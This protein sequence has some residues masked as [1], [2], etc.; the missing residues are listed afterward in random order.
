VPHVEHSIHGGDGGRLPRLL[1]DEGAFLAL[2]KP[3]GVSM[4]TS[5]RPGK[6]EADVV[7]R[8]LEACGL[9]VPAALPLLVHRLDEGTSGVVLLAR[10]APTHRLLS[11]AFQERA[12]NK[13]Y[14]AL[15]WG[16]PVPS[17]GLADAPL[18]RDPKDGRKMAVREGGKPAVTR[19][20][21]LR[22][23]P[24]V[25]DLE[26]TPETGR[27]HQIR[28]HLSEKGHPIVGDDFYGGAT[29]W[30]GV[31]DPV[32]RAAIAAVTHPLLHAAR[33]VV[34]SLGIDVEAP[35]PAEYAALLAILAA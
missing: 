14:R 10:D 3:A 26:L 30:R 7:G 9:S 1:L 32:T 18:A 23:Y 21:T 2:D 8:L 15:V 12:A 29:R 34:A 31:R 24:S 4:A 27:T 25:A 6:S 11:T 33:V 17:R 20:T 16:H 13:T 5:G 19:W 22:R 28:V 35:L